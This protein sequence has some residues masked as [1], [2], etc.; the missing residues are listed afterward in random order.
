[1]K[2]VTITI[3][4]A[5]VREVF[6]KSLIENGSEEEFSRANSTDWYMNYPDEVEFED[7]RSEVEQFM[8]S[9]GFIEGKDYEF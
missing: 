7:A 3:K 8:F 6:Q 1:M 2:S 4:D 9:L 5:Q